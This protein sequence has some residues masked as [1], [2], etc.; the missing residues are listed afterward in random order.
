MGSPIHEDA[1]LVLEGLGGSSAGFAARQLSV[2]IA[3]ASDL[4]LTMTRAHRDKV[5]ELVPQKLKRAFTLREAARLIIECG[6]Q[7]LGDLPT[8]RPYLVADEQLDITDPIGR[9]LEEFQAVGDQIATLL[10]PVLQLC[11]RSAAEAL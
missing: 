6:A 9:S 3:G 7:S 1:A 11:Q 2:K 5:L 10:P 4:I 8:L